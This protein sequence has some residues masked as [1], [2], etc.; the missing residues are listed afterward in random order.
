MAGFLASDSRGSQTTTSSVAFAT[1]DHGACVGTASDRV[2][3]TNAGALHLPSTCNATELLHKF[4]YLAECT[5]TQG[6]TFTE[7]SPTD[8]DRQRTAMM[9]NPI[10][11]SLR[12]LALGTN[13]K[14]FPSE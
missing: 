13:S 14:F 12:L 1:Y 11:E 7:Q 2:S 6:L 5:C 4:D 8:I 9:M 3:E 10:G